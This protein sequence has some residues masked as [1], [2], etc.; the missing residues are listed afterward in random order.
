V[1]GGDVSCDAGEGVRNT[2]LVSCGTWD[3]GGGVIEDVSGGA[4]EVYLERSKWGASVDEEISPSAILGASGGLSGMRA[5]CRLPP[6]S[7]FIA[8]VF[9]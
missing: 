3:E 6:L 7:S 9:S 5:G 8:R 4:G 1:G 2:C